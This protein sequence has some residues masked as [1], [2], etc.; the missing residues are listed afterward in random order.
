MLVCLHNSI[1]KRVCTS[2]KKV[3][4]YCERIDRMLNSSTVT[5]RDLESLHGNLNY[6][7]AV[8]PFARPFLVP[9]TEMISKHRRDGL[10]PTTAAIKSSLRIWKKILAANKGLSFNFI[11]DKLPRSNDIFTDASSDWGIGG[12]HGPYYY[13]Y[14][15]DELQ[16]FHVDVIARM[17]LLAA[18]ISLACFRDLIKGRYVQLFCDNSNVVSWLR[19]GRSSH[20]I[21]FRLLAVWELIKYKAQCKVSPQWLPGD[22]NC[23]ADSLSRGVVPPWLRDRGRQVHC[24]LQRLAYY[25]THA[26]ESWDSIL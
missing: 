6:A 3:N 8:A 1:T 21:G 10:A 12:C 22:K 14:S 5:V 25:V 16:A 17:E 15:W 20:R 23:T 9:L 26:E 2:S 18:L 11:L 19:K 13:L 7:A 24:D 4:K